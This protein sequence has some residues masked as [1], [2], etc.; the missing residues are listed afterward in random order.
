MSE[1]AAARAE[2]GHCRALSRER[3]PARPAGGHAGPHI[4]GSEPAGSEPAPKYQNITDL[5]SK[6]TREGDAARGSLPSLQPNSFLKI[7]LKSVDNYKKK[8]SAQAAFLVVSSGKGRRS[9]GACVCALFRA[10][11]C[12]I[13]GYYMAIT[14]QCQFVLTYIPDQR[15][16]DG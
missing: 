7:I 12:C 14:C 10:C 16:L 9:C 3:E 1:R 13:H 4:G 2:Q 8:R 15:V 5:D 6:A 11:V